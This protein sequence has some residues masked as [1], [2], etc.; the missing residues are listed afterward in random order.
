MQQLHC[1]VMCFSIKC[2]CF[3]VMTDCLLFQWLTWLWH[4]STLSTEKTSCVTEYT[5][6]RR[7][8]WQSSSNLGA[9][10][11]SKVTF[12]VSLH[13]LS[14][15]LSLYLLSLSV[16]VSLSLLL[17]VHLSLYIYPRLSLSPVLSPLSLSLSLSL[18]L[19]CRPHK[20]MIKKN[21]IEFQQSPFNSQIH[22]NRYLLFWCKLSLKKLPQLV[23]REITMYLSYNILYKKDNVST[24]PRTCRK[25][26][27]THVMVPV[28]VEYLL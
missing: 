1:L 8:G 7:L 23:N 2:Q 16:S 6:I 12:T 18:S 19:V 13:Y 21:H 20:W 15:C 3:P 11:M 24:A 26:R 22:F 5:I 9:L 25:H 17:S 14:V 28:N 10:N 4:M 27:P